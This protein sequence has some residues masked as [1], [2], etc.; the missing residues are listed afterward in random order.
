MKK[1]KLNYG[2]KPDVD[3]RG[4]PQ[5][6]IND[7]I[8]RL[9]YVN[10]KVEKLL[11]KIGIKTIRD[12]L[13][14][15][16]SRYV[17]F[18]N[19]KKM[20][21]IAIG[22]TCTVQG[23][24]LS[25]KNRRLPWGKPNITEAVI[26]DNTRSVKAVWF[27]QPFLVRN[28]KEGQIINISGKTSL[29]KKDICFSHPTYEIIGKKE[30]AHTGRIVPIY[31]ETK[32]LTS[33]W[34]RFLMAHALKYAEQI[35]D[36]LPQEIIIKEN[37]SP[38]K[39]AIKNLHFPAT[40]QESQKAKKQLA[41]EEL[42]II[43]LMILSL[44]KEV[45]S[46][47]APKIKIDIDSVKQFVSCLPFQ[48]TNDQKK[49]AWQILKDTEKPSPMNR[50]L[51]GDVGSGK[52]IV[53]AIAALNTA[54]DNW[55]VAY[56]APTEILARQHF[57]TFCK[58]LRPFNLQIALSTSS[59]SKIFDPELNQEYKVKKSD[60][61]KKIES[62]QI[63]IAI[64]THALIQKKVKFS[65][66]GLVIIDEQHRF[67]VAQRAAL[68]QA[69]NSPTG[70]TKLFI[71]HLLSMTA[72]PI[73]R[74]LMLTIYGD[75]DVSIL[76][77]MPKNRQK[78]ITKIIMPQERNKVYNFIKEEIK[79]GRQIFVICPRIESSES[80]ITNYELRPTQQKLLNEEV[81]NVKEEYKKLSEEIFQD[82]KIA[83]LHGKLKPKEKEEIMTNLKNNK[84]NILVSTSVIEVG[85]DIPNATVMMIESADRF[86]LAQLHQFRGRIGRG[87]HQ[88]YCFLM[89]ES[90]D[91][92][93]ND[94]LQALIKSDNGFQLAQRDLEIRGPGE[95]LGARQSGLADMAFVSFA[96]IFLLEKVRNSAIT[97]FKK[98]PDLQQYPSLKS[99]IKKLEQKTHLE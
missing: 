80:Q 73:P 17:D 42:F 14:R 93:N 13:M 28:M 60:L 46:Q 53:A 85:I 61:L 49:S 99:Q 86:G 98:D 4:Q 10:P 81:K 78:I 95:F 50:L 29:Y 24:I 9:P 70:Q 11:L 22:E 65:K 56:I 82:L 71:P 52:T 88:S 51:N 97:L 91:K 77:E 2:Q 69:P 33:R 5:T 72:T 30:L 67:G 57:Q 47:K 26:T 36:I 6:T 96:D 43:Q 63:N 39:I 74:T 18:S 38:L 94:R 66:L 41:F 55:Q 19:I 44:K 89:A 37:L 34:I 48:L 40:I 76:N 1:T 59:E 12:L 31:P 68:L 35:Q 87:H 64:G 16:P 92:I 15:A 32:G 20:R 79:N 23:K 84:I 62:A 58:F 25:I 27:N 83:M 45:K 90:E 75:L 21:D 8:S 3:I 7:P 54:K